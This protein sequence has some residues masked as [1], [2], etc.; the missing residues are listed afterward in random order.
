MGNVISRAKLILGAVYL[1]NQAL[2]TLSK[3]IK[4]SPGLPVPNPSLPFWTIPKSTISSGKEAL[5][6]YADIVVIG[7]GITGTS[8]VYNALQRDSSIRVLVL[9]ARDVC[10]GATGRYDC[11]IVSPC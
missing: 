6:E 2:D 10:S 9:E 5:P 4:E 7:S 3:R 11:D 8:F 1:I